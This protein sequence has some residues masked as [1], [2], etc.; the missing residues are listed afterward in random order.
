MKSIYGWGLPVEASTYAKDVDFG[1]RLIHA[2]M[3]TIFILWAIFFVYLLVRYRRREGVPAKRD[4]EHH[5]IFS[6]SLIPD[7]I[8]MLFEIALIF[9]YAI[10]VW[11]RIK[12]HAPDVPPANRIDVVAEQFAWNIHYPGADGKFGRTEMDKIHFS[13][14]LGLDYSDPAAK[15]DIVLANEL[16]LPT[17]RPTLIRLTSLDVIH[18]F[19][20]PSFRIKQDIVPG[21]AIPLWVEPDRPGTYELSCAQLCGFA[22]SLMR[23]TVIV[24]TPEDYAKWLK[25]AA[26]SVAAASTNTGQ[27]W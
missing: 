24:Q 14:P 15:D 26:P 20:I 5:G 12:G 9:F 4:P 2:A 10:P 11:S 19:W 1:I 22:H 7:L 23:A 27:S 8:V 16:H 25:S 13:N 6:A 17:G 21:M 3:F 18:S